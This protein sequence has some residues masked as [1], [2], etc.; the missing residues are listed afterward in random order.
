MIHNLWMEF[1]IDIGLLIFVAYF[2][3]DAMYAVYT[4]SVVK[5]KPFT[6]ASIGA[7]MHFL[8][9]FGV[10]NYVQNYLYIVPL[11]IGSFCGTYVVVF[12]ERRF[13]KKVSEI[14]KKTEE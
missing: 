10:I 9:A 2:L 12:Y 3:I 1:D 13:S 11:A 4:L 6:S 8:L 14:I 5:K 7:V